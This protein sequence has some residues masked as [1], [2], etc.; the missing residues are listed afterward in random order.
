[1]NPP[2]AG[3]RG[4]TRQGRPPI[5]LATASRIPVPH[6][7]ADKRQMGRLLGLGKGTAGYRKPHGF[8]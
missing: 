7:F 6:P 5:R 2:E 3:K 4:W 1:M 8:R